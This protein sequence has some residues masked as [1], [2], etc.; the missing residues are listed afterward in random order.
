MSDHIL[1]EARGPTLELR[2]NRPDKK[3][4]LTHAMY[5][6]LADAL[7]A[8][9]RDDSVAVATITGSS[10]VFTS[11]NDLK[12]FQETPPV[13]MDKPVY[14]F[15]RAI[16]AFPKVLVAGVSGPAVGIGTTMLLHC[17][18]VVATRSALFHMPFVDLGLVPEA[19]SSLLFPRLVGPQAA[20]RH[21]ILG[22]PFDAE[23]ALAYGLI[24]EIVD[25]DAL[26][27]RVRALAGQVA[28]KPPEAV[29]LTKRLIR[30]GG[31]SVEK[32]YSEE[33][34]LFAERLRSP[35]AA[36]AFRAFFEKR[37]AKFG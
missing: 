35:E 20:A 13:G 26:E 17:D 15:I 19:A 4:A 34:E 16:A 23:R 37:P 24:G 30:S 3:N 22:E 36:E 12:D 9:A 25:E 31:D 6:A 29:R 11:G 32:R 10:G 7:E 1:V 27:S 28:A 21:L 2:I 14:R 5:A 8:A 18:L 33:G